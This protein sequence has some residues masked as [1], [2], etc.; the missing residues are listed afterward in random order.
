MYFSLQLIDGDTII[1]E[2]KI[3]LYLNIDVKSKIYLLYQ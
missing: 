2:N 3:A 1:K